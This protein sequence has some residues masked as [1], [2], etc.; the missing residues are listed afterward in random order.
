VLA[1]FTCSDV[2]FSDWLDV[3]HE[4][5]VSFS[6]HQLVLEEIGFLLDFL[7]SLLGF[8]S[9]SFGLL[10]VALQ[11]INLAFRLSRLD[12]VAFQ[13]GLDSLHTVL[14]VSD[15]QFGSSFVFLQLLH[16]RLAISRLLHIIVEIVLQICEKFLRFILALLNGPLLGLKASVELLLLVEFILE[17]GSGCL[18]AG[19]GEGDAFVGSLPVFAFELLHCCLTL[20]VFVG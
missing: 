17:R 9:L 6:F 11:F 8:G 19:L 1:V 2:D 10:F 13:S 12:L 3:L 16:L 4:V 5:D 14:G 7:Q 15:Y 18:K 20:S